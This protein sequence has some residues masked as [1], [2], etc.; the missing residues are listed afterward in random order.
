MND[1]W[2]MLDGSWLMAQGSWLMAKEG[3]GRLIAHGQ[4]PAGPWGPKKARQVRQM[5]RCESWETD[6]DSCSMR[7]LTHTHIT[8]TPIKNIT[9]Q[10]KL[11]KHRHHKLAGVDKQSDPFLARGI[12][13]LFS[14]PGG[15]VHSYIYIYIYKYMAIYTW[16]CEESPC[17]FWNNVWPCMTYLS[18]WYPRESLGNP[19]ISM[20]VNGYHGRPMEIY[21]CCCFLRTWDLSQPTQPSPAHPTDREPA[22]GVLDVPGLALEGAGPFQISNRSKIS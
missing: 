1:A 18:P 17:R 9:K 12:I 3:Q 10:Y 2:C 14:Y 6:L 8:H 15:S 16:P 4:G 21:S 13:A 5:A 19:W 7:V 11:T 20:G 22:V